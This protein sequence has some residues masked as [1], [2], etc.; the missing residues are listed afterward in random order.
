MG[1]TKISWITHHKKI[2]EYLVRLSRSKSS[3]FWKHFFGDTR[4]K[5]AETSKGTTFC[6]G[7]STWPLLVDLCVSVSLSYILFL[8]SL[9]SVASYS[10]S[11]WP[12][13]TFKVHQ[14]CS[15]FL[16]RVNN[17]GIEG[18]NNNWIINMWSKFTQKHWN[19]KI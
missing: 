11:S 3:A 12:L 10:I 18:Q 19:V 13:N 6:K 17:R 4:L 9:I 7:I 1:K 8:Y 15:S 5:C 14:K 16:W 2:R